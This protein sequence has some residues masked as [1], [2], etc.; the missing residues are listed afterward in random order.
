[1]NCAGGKRP[2][3]SA[4]AGPGLQSGA[5][6]HFLL[7]REELALNGV[8]PARQPMQS[9]A[10]RLSREPRNKKDPGTTLTG[11]SHVRVP[12]QEVDFLWPVALE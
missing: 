8:V 4:F 12:P 3:L 7:C 11:A 5:G 6:H 1:M 10:A 2:P 9:R